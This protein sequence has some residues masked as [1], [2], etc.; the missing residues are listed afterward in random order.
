MFNTIIKDTGIG[1][2]Q[3]RV[4][5]LFRPFEELMHVGQMKLVKDNSIGLGLSNS[6][7]FTDAL[8]GQ[9]LFLKCEPGDT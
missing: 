6:K 8:N 3:T 4:G 9:I 5:L 1:I 2:N 7:I